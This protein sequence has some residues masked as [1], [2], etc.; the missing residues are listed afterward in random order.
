MKIKEINE[1]GILG[2]I[3]KGLAAAGTGL[4]RGLDKLGGGTGSNVGTAQQQKTRQQALLKKAN[5]RAN[6]D[7]VAAEDFKQQMDAQGI[8]YDPADPTSAQAYSQEAQKFATTFFAGG[9]SDPEIKSY[10]VQQIKTHPLPRNATEQMVNKYFNEINDIRTK[11]LL[12]K[13]Q[14]RLQGYTA[15]QTGPQTTSPARKVGSYSKPKMDTELGVSRRNPPKVDV[16]GVLYTFDFNMGK[17]TDEDHL[18]IDDPK[19]ENELNKKY[20]VNSG[21]PLAATQSAKVPGRIAAAASRANL[22]GAQSQPPDSAASTQSRAS[23]K[24]TPVSI[25]D[26]NGKTFQFNDSNRKWYSNR[27]E[28]TDPSSIEKLNQAALVQFQ[29][30]E[31]ARK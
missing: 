26:R 29:N 2:N 4:V 10:I 24:L 7:K 23:S 28:I 14:G 19:D 8:K 27:Q 30:R 15:T 12:H 22:A 31:M 17:W 20:Y 9:E 18:P 21:R 25:K 5:Q 6:L 3:G 13:E 1:A 16:N 11:A